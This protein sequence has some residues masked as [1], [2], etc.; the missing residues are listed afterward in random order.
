MP[1]RPPDG[2]ISAPAA[3]V[4]CPPGPDDDDM[5]VLSHPLSPSQDELTASPPDV[6]GAVISSD[7]MLVDGLGKG[8]PD[9]WLPH[10]SHASF[11]SKADPS[12]VLG[13]LSPWW[14]LSHLVG[15]PHLVEVCTNPPLSLGSPL[16]SAA[17]NVLRALRSSLIAG[18]P[19]LSGLKVKYHQALSLFGGGRWTATGHSL[20]R[21][22]KS[23]RVDL[24]TDL[25]VELDIRR[26]WPSI[27]RSVLRRVNIST[28]GLDSS[29]SLD[30]GGFTSLVADFSRLRKPP[31]DAGQVKQ[32]FLA[33]IMQ[34]PAHWPKHLGSSFGGN[35]FRTFCGEILQ[36]SNLLR[37]AFP[38]PSA[39]SAMSPHQHLCRLLRAMEGAVVDFALL[40][41]AKEGYVL[42]R[43]SA[44]HLRYISAVLVT[45]LPVLDSAPYPAAKWSL[46]TPYQD[47]AGDSAFEVLLDD[48]FDT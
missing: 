38:L 22:P 5:G 34:D 33:A 25:L 7:P 32:L 26:C 47:V 37:S 1:V 39:H 12:S 2:H 40:V 23:L 11:F 10:S 17:G 48:V 24:T 42:L 45:S 18:T 15:Q 29:I 36:A 14:C 16:P 28:P 20:I 21:L 43:F 30:G 9:A 4:D 13:R 41:S 6:I 27:L 46:M 19:N 3:S 35:L 8:P 31:L 44:C